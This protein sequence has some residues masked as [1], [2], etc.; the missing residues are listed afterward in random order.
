MHAGTALSRSG[1]RV[2]KTATSGQ[3]R[4]TQELDRKGVDR[5]PVSLGRRTTSEAS[6]RFDG[7]TP[8]HSVSWSV[9]TKGSGRDSVRLPAVLHLQPVNVHKRA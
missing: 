2:E 6:L 1:R 7:R 5:S 8:K 4:G 3:Q 9:I